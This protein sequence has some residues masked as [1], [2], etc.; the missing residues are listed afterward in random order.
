MTRKDYE[1]IAAAI[2]QQVRNAAEI[3]RTPHE[4]LECLAIGMANRLAADNPN[5]NRDLFLS[6]CGVK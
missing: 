2:N 3:A 1:I 5:F 4:N 6:A